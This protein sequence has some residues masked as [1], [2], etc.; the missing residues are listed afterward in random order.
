M[1]VVHI[2]NQSEG[3]SEPPVFYQLTVTDWSNRTTYF[4]KCWSSNLAQT[5]NGFN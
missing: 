1:N 4:F 2:F 3:E 5:R